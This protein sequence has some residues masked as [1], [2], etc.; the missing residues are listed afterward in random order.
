M[1]FELA[2]RH[3][4]VLRALGEAFFSHASGPHP[5]QLDRV[6]RGMELHLAPI[7][8]PQRTVL[9]LALDL[10]R[11]LPLL[12]CIA[13]A[14]FEGLTVER[15]LRVLERMDRSSVPLLLVPL[16]AYKSLLSMHFFEDETELRAMG[17]PGDERARW[18]R[19][20]A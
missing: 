20:L 4:A 19:I 12:L 16:V 7:S 13:W 2:P 3:R 11:W 5:A 8:R 6:V 15:R 18:R 14:P 9:L 17:Y 10:I 1:T